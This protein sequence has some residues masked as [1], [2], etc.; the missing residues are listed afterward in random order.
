MA[1][2]VAVIG[3]AASVVKLVGISYKV[4]SRISKVGG[5]AATYQQPFERIGSQL[6]LLLHVVEPVA[7]D[8]EESDL[9]AEV[10]KALQ[11]ALHGCCE[12][13]CSLARVL[14][15]VD[16]D[17]EGS[18]LQR[19]W[20]VVNNM[21][22]EKRLAVIE[23]SL[24]QYKSTITL[25]LA[26]AGSNRNKLFSSP[27][28]L[29]IFQVPLCQIS[30]LVGRQ[31]WLSEISSR[32][33]Q[34][35]KSLPQPTIV[36]IQGMGGL[37]KTRLAYEFCQRAWSRREYKCIFWA[38]ASNPNTLMR[39]FDSFLK[40]F[41]DQSV[42]EDD[43]A[44]I[45]FIKT[46]LGKMTDPWLIVYDNFDR[47]SLFQDLTIQD[48][49]PH[50]STGRSAILITSRHLDSARLGSAL[51][52][53][54]MS[55]EEGMDLLFQR[56]G[57]IRNASDEAEARIIVQSLACL[58]LAIDQAAAYIAAR[59]MRLQHFH[60]HN[61]DRKAIVLSHTPDLWEYRKTIHDPEKESSLS[62][63]TT[64]ELSLRQISNADLKQDSKSH[65]LTLSGFMDHHNISESIFRNYLDSTERSATEPS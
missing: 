43:Q 8:I 41:R 64:W 51:H 58:P 9:G 34:S 59:G 26:H 42:F 56:S 31:E 37:G 19:S 28:E 18:W 24:E 12:E 7:E 62:V 20:K 35:K 25:H 15:A 14:D 4:L 6:P 39:S 55:E 61:R 45:T 10:Q 47:P 1:E 17:L 49:I 16:R 36:V 57:R 53:T 2:A 50:D 65:F 21:K 30:Q 54:G 5:A 52:I 13:I 46:A 44:K 33:A 3:I 27:Q 40:P 48:C 60:K 32:L 23:R 38:D 63:F 11:R 29:S 22:Y